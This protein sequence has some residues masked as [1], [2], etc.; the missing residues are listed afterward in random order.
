MLGRFAYISKVDLQ[1][2]RDFLAKLGIGRKKGLRTVESALEGGRGEFL[3]FF[4]VV[5]VVV[6]GRREAGGRQQEGR[7]GGLDGV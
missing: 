3:S 6:L 7:R 4:F 1:A 5:V 2:S